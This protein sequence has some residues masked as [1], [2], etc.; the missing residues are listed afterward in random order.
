[1]ILERDWKGYD[2]RKEARRVM[3]PTSSLQFQI[4]RCK[5]FI[6]T[7]NKK[8]TNVLMCGELNYNL[9]IATKLVITKKG[10]N[11]LDVNPTL[12]ATGNP[13][14]SKKLKDVSH[15]LEKHFGSNW[16]DLD[17]LKWYKKSCQSN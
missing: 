4:S 7:R 11:F 15:L 6:L 14:V 1:M 17:R 13:I 12:L 3:K 8:R 9:D 16:A 2:W 5:R 10:L